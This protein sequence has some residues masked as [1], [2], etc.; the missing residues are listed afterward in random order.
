M[1][2]VEWEEVELAAAAE[3]VAAVEEAGEGEDVEV[4]VVR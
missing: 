2:V 1:V 3:V 4:V